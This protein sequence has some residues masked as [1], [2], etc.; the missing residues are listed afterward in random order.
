MS[1]HSL[2][3]PGVSVTIEMAKAMERYVMTELVYVTTELASAR[4][5]SAATENFLSRQ[6]RP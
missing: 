6:R 5:I 3:R 2:S 4:R 1:R